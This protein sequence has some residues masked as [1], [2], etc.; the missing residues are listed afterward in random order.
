MRTAYVDMDGLLDAMDT[1]HPGARFDLDLE[2]GRINLSP[3]DEDRQ[4]EVPQRDLAAGRL[5][6]QSFTASVGDAE[7]R[8]RLSLALDHQDAF[9]LFRWAVAAYP[10]L[11]VRWQARNRAALLEEALSWLRSAGI[12]PQYDL[13]PVPAPRA[14]GTPPAAGDPGRVGLLELLL[15]GVPPKLPEG[16]DG[17]LLRQ[18]DGLNADHAHRL[19]RSLARQLAEHHGVPFE[20]PSDSLTIGHTRLALTGARVELWIQVPPAV[21]RLFVR[22]VDEPT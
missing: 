5:L 3:D 6:M 17:R 16:E 9:F 1:H 18:V 22:P 13:R 21:R 14:L 7:A 2:S 4:L 12:E 11:R 19:F 8:A 15:L 10:D 20:E